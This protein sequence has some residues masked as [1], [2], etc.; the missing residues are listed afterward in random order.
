MTTV[1]LS[2]NVSFNQIIDLV[3]KLSAKEKQLLND[4]IWD[5]NMPIPV[6]HQALV[7]DRVAESKK[8]SESMLDWELIENKLK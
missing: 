6:Q 1:P 7:L 5:Q 8:T 4:V 3:K 2:I